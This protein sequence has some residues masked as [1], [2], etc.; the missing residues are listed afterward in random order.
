MP[1]SAAANSSR[2]SLGGCLRNREGVAALELALIAPALLT[3]AGGLADFGLAFGDRTQLAHAVAN[4][5][6]YAFAA[7]EL[8][9]S[10]GSVSAS[11]VQAAVQAST[12]LSNVVVVVTGPEPGCIQTNS[13]ASPPTSTLIVAT[14]S[15][16]TPCPNGN[17]VGTYMVITAQYTYQPLMPFYSALASQTLTASAILRLY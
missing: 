10:I 7:Q 12:A 9:G 17:P 6:A 5:A 3:I 2:Q 16:G 11:S 8:T 14:S 4:G 15:Y 13:T 1:S